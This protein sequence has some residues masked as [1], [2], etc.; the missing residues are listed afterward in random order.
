MVFIQGKDHSITS[1]WS[2]LHSHPEQPQPDLWPLRNGAVGVKGITQGHL[3]GGNE[4][5]ASA[6]LCPQPDVPCQ[7]GDLCWMGPLK[8]R[9]SQRFTAKG[10][11]PTVKP[12]VK[13]PQNMED[14]QIY[15]MHIIFNKF[16][17]TCGSMEPR[18]VHF[19]EFTPWKL[20]VK[21]SSSTMFASPCY[22]N[23][24][25]NKLNQIQIWKLESRVG[26]VVSCCHAEFAC[27]FTLH[28]YVRV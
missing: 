21:C 14:L 28:S 9:F 8:A 23:Q 4:G 12:N 16:H 3:S 11:W 17:Q 1:L 22:Q 10:K 20:E 26:G 15:R 24:N 13:H 27:Q 19:T 18:F 6:C 5:G 25:E 2:H 7:S